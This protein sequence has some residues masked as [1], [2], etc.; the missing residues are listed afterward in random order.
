MKESI[1]HQKQIFYF[2]ALV[3]C[4][5]EGLDAQHHVLLTVEPRKDQ[6]YTNAADVEQKDFRPRLR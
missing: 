5:L 2:L 3:H 4:M 1:C 6:T